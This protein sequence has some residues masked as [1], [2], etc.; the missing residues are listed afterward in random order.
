MLMPSTSTKNNVLLVNITRLGDMLQATPTIAGIKTG[1]RNAKVTVVVE[2]QFQD[3]CRHLPHIDEVVALDLSFVA[4]SISAEGEALVD[5][6]EYVSEV[7]KNS[8]ITQFR[9]L[10]E[11]VF[12]WLH[13][14]VVTTS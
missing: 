2:K 3:I 10:S 6:Y 12:I 9:L 11:Y 4:R 14:H 13:R 5:A 7:I 1:N 8:K